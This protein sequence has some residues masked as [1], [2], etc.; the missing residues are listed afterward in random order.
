MN[1]IRDYKWEENELVSHDNVW[2]YVLRTY[3]LRKRMRIESF[4][5]GPRRESL[6]DISK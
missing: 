1:S 5:Q 3:T 4:F 6:L 2:T